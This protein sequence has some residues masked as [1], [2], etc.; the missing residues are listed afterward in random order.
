M[1]TA[2]FILVRYGGNGMARNRSW[3]PVR[4]GIE[5]YGLYHQCG[6]MQAASS[7]AYF[8]IL[9]I[10][11]LLLCVNYLIGLFQIDLEQLLLSVRQFLPE[12][13]LDVLLD[14][15]N[16]A[17]HSWAAGVPVAAVITIVLSASAGLRILLNALD[18]IYGRQPVR[19]IKRF[20]ESVILSVLLVLIL[21]L[22]VVVIFTGGWFFQM[23][24]RIL[25]EQLI[26]LL[27]L[28]ALSILWGVLRYVLLFSCMLLLVL[29]L[30][31]I[32]SPEK[33][34]G[35]GLIFSAML[36]SVVLV[37]GSAVF[38]GFIVLSTRYSVVYGSLAS[39]MIL[40][41]WLYFCGNMLLLGALAGRL[42]FLRDRR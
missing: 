19:G 26:E 38:S 11:P 41:V 21:Y 12:A 9:T 18:R 5:F 14:Y 31:W 30:Y 3:S 33:L 40:L 20:A 37:L 10:F 25:P 7:L 28:R 1:Q 23:L 4:V 15:L 16:Y 29:M 34:R 2:F 8:M 24:E 13:V 32:G 17:S 36:T 22:S 42:L 6:G 39:L 35:W 27:P